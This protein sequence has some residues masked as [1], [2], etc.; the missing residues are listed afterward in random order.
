MTPKEYLQ[1]YRHA[2]ERAR[3]ALEHLQELQTMA[4]RT[5]PIY[6]GEGGGQ[7]QSGDEKLCNAVERIIEAKNRVSDE[8]EML[9]ATEREVVKTIDSVTDNAL[10]TLLYKRY[11]NGKTFEQIAVEMNYSYYHVVHRLHPEALEAV[12]MLL[13]V[14][15]EV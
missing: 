8:L 14:T 12:K 10:N 1:Q 3:S 9:E 15:S 5:T 13:N 2:V 6:G 11:I 4:T 7:H